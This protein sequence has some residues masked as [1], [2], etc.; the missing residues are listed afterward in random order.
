MFLAVTWRREG[1]RLVRSALHS[2]DDPPVPFLCSWP[3]LVSMF[4]MWVYVFYGLYVGPAKLHCGATPPSVMVLLWIVIV[5]WNIFIQ[6][7]IVKC[8]FNSSCKFNQCLS[9]GLYGG[10]RLKML[11]MKYKVFVLSTEFQ[12]LCCQQSL[13]VKFKLWNSTFHCRARATGS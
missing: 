13:S 11:L 6:V 1:R 7:V 8:C 9:T 10:L 4:A 2:P 12:C 5:K 3:F